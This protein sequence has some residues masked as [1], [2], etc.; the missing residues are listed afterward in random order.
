MRLRHRLPPQ[1]RLVQSIPSWVDP[2]ALL[3]MQFGPD[4]YW[5]KRGGL[6]PATS[7]LTTTRS[8]SI[9]L[10]NA[11]G[12][13]QTLGN[14]T[15]PRTD[16]GLYANG[17][18]T[19]LNANG[20]N[21]QS[22]TGWGDNGSP[23]I[24]NGPT[25][26]GFFQS[27]YVASPDPVNMGTR[28]GTNAFAATAGTEIFVKVRFGAGQNDSGNCRVYVSGVGNSILE[29]PRG[30]LA[31]ISTASGTFTILT[32]SENEISFGFTPANTENL[33]VRGGP[34]AAF[35]GEDIR[36]DGIDNTDQITD[37]WVSTSSPAPTLLASDIRAAQGV[38]PSNSQPEPFPGWEAA[39]LDD[40]MAGK[41]VVN[42]DR[43]N[44]SAARFITGAGV[45]ADNLTKLIF[46][47]DNRFKLIVRKSGVDEVTLQTGAVAATGD[48]TIE[49]QAKPGDYAIAATGVAGDTDSD[50]ATLPA[51]AT[52][53]R[54]GSNFGVLNPFN[55]WISEIQIAR[56]A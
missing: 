21:P 16:R 36:L 22:A 27:V 5:R 51:G 11:A 2:G 46:D 38:R 53:L 13:Y 55:G 19:A 1:S 23:I 31:P 34:G 56:A 33:T 49:W 30:T 47:T 6:L 8:S 10:P 29:G 35:P 42:I 24:S 25:V 39:G 37:A 50:G 15:L 28:R 3:A 4:R 32:Q 17:Q 18:I 48:K 12:V 41:A 7:V 45:D 52:T 9:N 54:I 20:N 40:A 14:D 44:A 26:G 43:L